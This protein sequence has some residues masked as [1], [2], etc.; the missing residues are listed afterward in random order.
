M[1]FK[2]VFISLLHNGEIIYFFFKSETNVAIYNV[3]NWGNIN[4]LAQI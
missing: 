2:N 4:S 3:L 1:H